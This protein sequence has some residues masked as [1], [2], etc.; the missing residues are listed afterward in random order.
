MRHLPIKSGTKEEL[1]E[2]ISTLSES[3]VNYLDTLSPE[4]LHRVRASNKSLR[5][6][7]SKVA[8][9]VCMGPEKCLFVEHCPIPDRTATGDFVRDKSGNPVYGPDSD[10]PVARPCIMESMYIQQKLVDYVRFLDVD[11][12]N[13]IEMSIANE[14]AL[15]D[16][17]KNRALII[18]AKGDRDDQGQD[19]MRVDITG[20]DP[21]TG[22][23]SRS[24]SLHPA[25]AVLESIEKRRDK[26]IERLAEHRKSKIDLAYKMGNTGSDDKV[27]SELR[28][29]REALEKSSGRIEEAQ[30]VIRFELEA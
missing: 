3:Q 19:F 2:T 11:P 13:P 12:N 6:G 14:L 1:I 4:K 8:P 15:I 10:Y 22:I 18:L 26:Y 27:M 23:K 9:L 28:A 30:E 29:L 25:V 21:E 17:H 24:T 20:I 5:H 16:L 7:L